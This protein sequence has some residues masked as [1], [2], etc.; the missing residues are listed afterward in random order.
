MSN[1][2][3]G[4]SDCINCSFRNELGTIPVTFKDPENHSQASA[5]KLL[6]PPIKIKMKFHD[7]N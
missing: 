2:E 6:V 3:C 5:V 1:N 7:K 4:N